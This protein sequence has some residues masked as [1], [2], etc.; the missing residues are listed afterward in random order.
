[1]NE[2]GLSLDKLKSLLT[3]S[4]ATG[5]FTWKVSRGSVMRGDRAGSLDRAG[6]IDICIDRLYYRASRLAWFYCKGVWPSFEIDH[7][8]GQRADNRFRNLRD[9]TT[10][11]NQQNIRKA[12]ADSWSGFLGVH[13]MPRKQRWQARIS[14]DGR[15]IFL[16]YFKTAEAGHQ[17]YLR[18][19]RQHH[20]GSTI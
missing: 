4:R 16:G 15:R 3:Y 1:M 19:K 11:V 18:Y 10:T 9:V 6:Y 14:V 20:P 13:W 7:K 2:E 17:A 12:H 5:E 8:N